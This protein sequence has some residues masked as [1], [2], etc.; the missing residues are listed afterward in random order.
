MMSDREGQTP[1]HARTL[2]GHP[3]D[4]ASGMVFTAADDFALPGP[5]Q[6]L[7]RRYYNTGNLQPGPFGI[8]WVTSFSVK[9]GFTLG[10]LVFT[11]DNGIPVLLDPPMDGERINHPRIQH[12]TIREGNRYTVWDW[13]HDERFI[14]DILEERKSFRLTR[15][16]NLVGHGVDVLYRNGR[17]EGLVDSGGRRLRIEYDERGLVRA[18]SLLD[19]PR[20][21]PYRLVGYEYSPAGDLT[22]AY[23]H[24]GAPI[25]Y[26]YDD[27]HRLVR[28]TNRLGGSFHFRYDYEGRCIYNSADNGFLERHLAYD[29]QAGTT[30]V[31]NSVG[32]VTVYAV[33][34]MGLVA[35]ET[36]PL[37][38]TRFKIHNAEGRVVLD[39]DALG[40]KTAT[41]YDA[42]GHM[43][44]TVDPLG[45]ELRYTFNDLHLCVGMTDASGAAWQFAYDER[46]RLTE[47][48]D[49]LGRAWRCSYDEAGRPSE[50]TTQDGT[51]VSFDY[52]EHGQLRRYGT[53][54]GDWEL[55]YDFLGRLTRET[56]PT[57][58]VRAWRY[59]ARSRSEAVEAGG[60]VKYIQRDAD[61]NPVAI[62]GARTSRTTLTYD[63]FGNLLQTVNALGHAVRYQYD[64]EGRTVAIENTAGERSR[65]V[66]DLNGELVEHVG[67]DGRARRLG[68]DAAG[69]IIS[70]TDHDGSTTLIVRDAAGRILRKTFADE[71]VA[72]FAYDPAGRLVQAL[73]AVC[74]LEFT[75]DVAGRLVAERQNDF[76]VESAYDATGNRSE[77]KGPFDY[78]VGFTYRIGAGLSSCVLP[79]ERTVRFDT[80]AVGR[81]TGMV[82]WSGLEVESKYDSGGRLAHR[83][84]RI[85]PARQLARSYHYDSDG[86]LLTIE[87]SAAGKQSFEYDALGRL[88]V[89]QSE[90]AWKTEYSF[91]P[92]GNLLRAGEAVLAR[93][94]AGGR[95][96]SNHSTRFELDARGN[97]ARRAS[98]TGARTFEFDFSNH[99]RR[100]NGSAGL[101]CEF[102][103]DP[104]GRRIAKIVNGKRTRFAW[105]GPRIIAEERDGDV[106]KYV[107]QPG[108]FVPLALVRGTRIYQYLCDHLGVAQHLVDENGGIAWQATHSPYGKV[109]RVERAEVENPLRHPGQYQDRE[110]GY[111]YN[112]ARY[113]DADLGRYLSPDPSMLDSEENPYIYP[114]N[115]L[116]WVDPYGLFP[117]HGIGITEAN[118]MLSAAG[119]P[120][121]IPPT[122]ARRTFTDRGMH[123]VNFRFRGTVPGG[124]PPAGTQTA[125][126]NVR[127]HSPDPRAFHAHPTSNS[128]NN[129]TATVTN[130]NGTARQMPDGSWVTTD[131]A[132]THPMPGTTRVATPA[133]MNDT[134]QPVA[135]PP[136]PNPLGDYWAPW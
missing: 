129:W 40:N 47:R 29:A 104:F 24:Y 53:P 85:A 12:E 54:T 115:P 28:E 27:Q 86:N 25:R 81:I 119:V 70:V 18:V 34:A 117:C 126:M 122:A 67:F 110:T 26:S 87:D 31:T 109:R 52:T 36:G 46:G 19:T 57:G 114:T 94:S 83:R 15:I 124:A 56:A 17:W 51:R 77:L 123:G 38:D 59:D 93:Y 43:V 68:R 63:A 80:D 82:S 99:L 58:E 102:E 11:N 90:D 105:D 79:G 76:I 61:G 72:E 131:P 33:N 42:A 96:V 113:F 10:K 39:F 6:L 107:Y 121:T 106:T 48:T 1:L 14:F 9:L 32:A 5:A 71:S 103:Y 64:S 50:V 100:I 128:G 37:G 13:H 125:W 136:N 49:P 16:E 60:A 4:V 120:V 112:L 118:A 75:Y 127:I 95:I 108:T 20:G 62:Q 65:T 30:R 8:G 84:A 69:Q 73:N 134:H 98:S 101:K 35:S 21:D 111:S 116:R 78:A 3:V 66:Y 133:D 7:W 89:E 92:A 135:T 91:D 88:R 45:A 2:V 132:A 23:D 97:I 22:V 44:A 55:E 74:E 41:D 130:N